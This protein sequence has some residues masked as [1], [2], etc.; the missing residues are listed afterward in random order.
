MKKAI[1]FILAVTIIGFS[2]NYFINSS[3]ETVG[4]TSGAGISMDNWYFERAYPELT[5]SLKGYLKAFQFNKE[6]IQQKTNQFDGEWESMGPINI[7]G[8]TLCLAFHPTDPDIMFVGAA[9]GGLWKTTTQGIG[10]EAWEFVP[11]GFPVIGVASIVIDP[12]NADNMLIGTGEVYGS[13]FAEPGINNRLT[14]GAYGIGILKSTD[15]GTTW[16]HVLEFEMDDIQGV[17]DMKINPQNTLEVYAATSNGLYQSL[18]GGDTWVLI[19]DQPNCMSVLVDP[20][21]GNILYLSQGNFNLTFDQNQSG[22]FK[23]TNKGE[24]FVELLDDGLL[25]AW[26]GNAKLYFEPENNNTLYASLQYQS[27]SGSSTDAGLFKSTNAGTTWNHINNQ[28]IALYQ[29]WYSH[30][31]AINPDNTSEIMYIGVEAWKST[32]G[33]NNFTVK[34]DWTGWDFGLVPVDYPEGTDDY[35]HADIHAVYYHPT[36]PNLVFMA[37]DGGVFKSTDGGENYITLNGGLQTTQ[38]YANLG[39]SSSSEDVLIGGAQDNATY[40]YNGT[41]S[42]SRVI[43]GDGMCAAVHQD[44]DDIVFGSAQR[45]N[46]RKSTNGG[47]YF[48]NVQPDFEP[49][50]SPIFNGP[51]EL[52]PSNNDIMYAGAQYLY[53]SDDSAE[54]W[55]A[56]SDQEVDGGNKI[57]SIAISPIN[58]DLVYITTA[59]DPLEGLS[60]AK[61]LKSTDGGSTFAI[62][63]GLPD[64]FCK[65]IAISSENDSIVFLTFSGFGTNHVYKTINA[66]VEWIV[67][68]AGLPDLPTNTVF[69]NPNISNHVYIGNDLGVYVSIDAG[70][71]W[72][73]FSEALPEA[74]MVM[75]INHSPANNNIRIAT[76][77]H[78]IYQRELL[79]ESVA[80]H[81]EI[82]NGINLQVFPNPTTS[83]ITIKGNVVNYYDNL[84]ITVFDNS[85]RIVF[86]KKELHP[87]S[88]FLNTTINIDQLA[89]GNYIFTLQNNGEELYQQVILKK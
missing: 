13:G 88:N 36:I 86:E 52:A 42:W 24:S 37:T 5:V 48:S 84:S 89:A 30:G 33:G 14:R 59:P 74:I 49:N 79:D 85:G 68:D 15:G 12:N 40:I 23:S 71:T 6:R 4:K 39:S 54:S 51:Y 18:D 44:N 61:V 10:Q 80:I 73:I 87:L 26:S 41:S 7:G 22:L 67:S 65:D 34:S 35:V 19:F 21:D 83:L 50:D 63:E 17:A 60:G 20:T 70:E 27:V 43:G 57:I 76:H 47:S 9:G 16:N 1:L 56:T 81:E 82:S 72:E 31:I 28:N 77:G 64:R 29:G 3:K 46:L 11:T 55:E 38:F 75:D 8:R 53:R 58:D 45:L 25:T 69:V 66:G 78:G 62:M 2:I 32:D